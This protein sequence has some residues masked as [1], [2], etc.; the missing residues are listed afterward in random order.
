V[1][2]LIARGRNA[3]RVRQIVLVAG[4]SLGLGILGAAHAHTPASALFWIT[5]SIG[6]LSAAS[7]VG[8]SIPSL[9]APAGS[10]GRLGGILNFGNQ[11][12]AIIAPIV[13]G[14]VITATQS[15]AWAF[16]VAT[17]FLLIGIAGYI[18]LLGRIEP[19]PEPA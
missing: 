9:I 1:N 3:S 16:V 17:V 10:V 4:T 8:W 7:P 14:Y 5:V 12:S 18:F 11:L 6:G 2:A 19:I 13:T 15:F